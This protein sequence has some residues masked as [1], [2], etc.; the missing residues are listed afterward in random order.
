[1]GHNID[2]KEIRYGSAEWIYLDQNREVSGP[3]ERLLSFQE[4]L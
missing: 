3:A 1:M 2:L 4:S